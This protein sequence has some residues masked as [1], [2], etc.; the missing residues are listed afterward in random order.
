MEELHRINSNPSIQLGSSP[1]LSISDPQNLRSGYNDILF[2]QDSLIFILVHP[3]IDDLDDQIKYSNLSNSN[4]RS[5][6]EEIIYDEIL[7]HPL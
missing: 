5:V 4:Q 6:I 3:I 2:H 1:Q 7:I